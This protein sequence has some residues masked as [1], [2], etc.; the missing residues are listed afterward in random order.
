LG[1]GLLK[2]WAQRTGEALANVKES[3]H[4]ERTQVIVNG[5]FVL[6]G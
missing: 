2:I 3:G 6:L 5:I 4:I 1:S